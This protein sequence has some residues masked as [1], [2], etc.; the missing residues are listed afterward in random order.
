LV[1][2]ATWAAVGQVSVTKWGTATIATVTA[3]V[4]CLALTQKIP[5]SSEMT[6]ILDLDIVTP[7]PVQAAAAGS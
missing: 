6:S 3:P 1:A 2:L 5:L 4:P 7:V